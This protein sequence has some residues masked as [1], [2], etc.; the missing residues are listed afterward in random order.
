MLFEEFLTELNNPEKDMIDRTLLLERYLNN[1]V[2]H[3]N[4]FLFWTD[5][6]KL[7]HIFFE[8]EG[9]QSIYSNATARFAKYLKDLLGEHFSDEYVVFGIQWMLIRFHLMSKKGFFDRPKAE[10]MN[11]MRE[12][13]GNYIGMT[14]LSHFERL[15]DLG[16]NPLR[17][18]SLPEG[19]V[20]PVGLPW[21][22]VENTMPEFR[23]LSNYLESGMST[24]SWKQLTV[25]TVAY[26]MRKISNKFALETTGAIAGS[27]FQL[28][29]F[30]TRGQS[31][32]ESGAINGVGFNLSS[33]GTDN[34]PSLWAARDFYFTENKTFGEHNCSV[35][36]GEHSVT[37]LGILTEQRRATANGEEIDLIEAERRYTRTIAT[38]RFPTGIVSFVADSFDYFK[39]LE[40]IVPSLYEEI[41]ARDGKFVVRGDSG[42]PVHIIAG[43]VINDLDMNPKIVGRYSEVEHVMYNTHLWWVAGN[44][45]IK[46]KGRYYKLNAKLFDNG[47]LESVDVTEITRV[48]AIGTIQHLWDVFGGDVNSLGYKVLD[49]HIGMIYGDGITAQRADEILTRLKNNKFASTNIV[50]GVGS[51]SLNMLSRDHLGIAIKATNAIVDIGGELVDAPIYKEPATDSSKKSDRG[52][53][54]VTEDEDGNIIKKDMQTREAM[55]HTGLLQDVYVNGVFHRL[56]NFSE[57]KNRLWGVV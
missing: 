9:T 8:T 7:S 32:F 55:L 4:P 56:T 17:V 30:S 45:V 14:E 40:E 38:E 3:V 46:F 18:K 12:T 41:M 48:E 25:A 24:D 15:H 10:V 49:S 28:H 16:F 31:G 1:K 27:E 39:F 13:L 54:V 42:N 35:P 6:Y 22:T 34:L 37:T 50:F 21:F 36:A 43:Y 44:E 5:S 11:E 53:L 47:M 33:V 26:A 29:D 51:Y 2:P 57:V 19:M 20:V 23:W 52:Y